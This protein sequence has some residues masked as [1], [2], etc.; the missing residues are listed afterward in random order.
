MPRPNLPIRALGGLMT[1]LGLVAAPLIAVP[2]TGASPQAPAPKT[3]TAE[4]EPHGEAK[5]PATPKKRPYLKKHSGH[6]GNPS[7][8]KSAPKPAPKKAPTPHAPAPHPGVPK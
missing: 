7:P 1:A 4:P 6:G 2:L 8:R 5:D 3:H